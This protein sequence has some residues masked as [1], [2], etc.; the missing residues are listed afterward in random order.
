MEILIGSIVI[1]FTL[2]ASIYAAS[3]GG[4]K[5]LLHLV[6]AGTMA[7]LIL[8]IIGIQIKAPWAGQAAGAFN[9]VIIALIASVGVSALVDGYRGQL[10]K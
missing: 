1:L 2:V 6:K 5:R 10:Q 3:Q 9:W 4:P 7:Y 8:L